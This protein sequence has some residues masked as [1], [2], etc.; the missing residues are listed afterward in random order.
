MK[1]TSA[2]RLETSTTRVFDCDLVR[3]LTILAALFAILG[4]T[5]IAVAAA[6]TVTQFPLTGTFLFPDG[7]TS[8]PDGAL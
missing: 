6:G 5:Q 3:R 7:I 2:A 8:G 1:R 4:T